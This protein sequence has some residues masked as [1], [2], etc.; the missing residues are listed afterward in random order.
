MSKS[1]G[2]FL[3]QTNKIRHPSDMSVAKAQNLFAFCTGQ[4]IFVA[5]SEYKTGYSVKI[6]SQS[7]GLVESRHAATKRDAELILKR[8]ALDAVVSFYKYDAKRY[9]NCFVVMSQHSQNLWG[10]GHDAA[11]AWRDAERQAGESLK[12]ENF[13]VHP[14]WRYK[15]LSDIDA[16]SV[17]RGDVVL[18]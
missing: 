18:L 10:I 3:K 1:L 17:E 8:Y 13:A 16:H 14:A 11:S 5:P 4:K 6:Y 12:K 2:M 15:K 7:I 9:A